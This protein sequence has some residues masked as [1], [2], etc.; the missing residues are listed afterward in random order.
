MRPSLTSIPK[1]HLEFSVAQNWQN[2]EMAVRSNFEKPPA[3]IL[4]F[5][6]NGVI[7]IQNKN[8]I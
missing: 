1:C 7:L 8:V 4:S 6:E 5:K 2:F 3:Q